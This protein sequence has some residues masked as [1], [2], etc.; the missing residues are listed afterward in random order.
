M[1]AGPQAMGP[2]D[3]RHRREE[4]DCPIISSWGE[5][6]LR[7]GVYQAIAE[8]VEQEACTIPGP[9]GWRIAFLCT[10]AGTG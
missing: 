9:M 4:G 7:N 2:S 5:R 8:A 3:E 6:I 1:V 10:V